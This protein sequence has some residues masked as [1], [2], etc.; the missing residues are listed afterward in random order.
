V[1]RGG[2]MEAIRLLGV[3]PG[4]LEETITSSEPKPHGNQYSGQSGRVRAGGS[5]LLRES[6]ESPFS[7]RVPQKA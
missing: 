4:V 6:S 5:Y 1:Q 2:E 3:R 7:R